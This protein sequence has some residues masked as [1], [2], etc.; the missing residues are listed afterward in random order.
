MMGPCSAPVLLS[1]HVT[2]LI[3]LEF[4]LI[5]VLS[6]CIV[7]TVGPHDFIAR[8]SWVWFF[9]AVPQLEQTLYFLRWPQNMIRTSQIERF[10]DW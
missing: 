7:A 8:F 6:L 3:I 1:P 5:L 2:S 9:S 4:D 10:G